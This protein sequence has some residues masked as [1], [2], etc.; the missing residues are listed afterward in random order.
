MLLFQA[1]FLALNIFV[2]TGFRFLKLKNLL[3]F[4]FF[5][6]FIFFGRFFFASFAYMLGYSGITIRQWL[7]YWF[8]KWWTHLLTFKSLFL[9]DL[10]YEIYYCQTVRFDKIYEQSHYSNKNCN[11]EHSG[12][13]ENKSIFQESYSRGFKIISQLFDCVDQDWRKLLLRINVYKERLLLELKTDEVSDRPI[14]Q[15]QKLLCCWRIE[16]EAIKLKSRFIQV[17]YCLF[18]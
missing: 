6:K 14:N 8:Q 5:L 3:F 18:C 7:W 4:T 13:Q 1:S 12:S 2:K 10:I 9:S 11:R 15:S 17:H 16:I